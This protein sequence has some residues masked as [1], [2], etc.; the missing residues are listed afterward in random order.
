VHSKGLSLIEIDNHA[1]ENG[2][3]IDANNRERALHAGQR[4]GE[5]GTIGNDEHVDPHASSVELRGAVASGCNSKQLRAEPGS[6]ES[7]SR[8]ACALR[9]DVLATLHT[10]RWSRAVSGHRRPGDVKGTS[11]LRTSLSKDR[12]DAQV[13]NVFLVVEG[14]DLG[15]DEGLDAVPESSRCLAEGHASAQPCGRCRMSAVVYAQRLLAD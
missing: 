5:I 9:P 11:L 7:S 10:A 2:R 14:A 12:V 13:G 4:V 3:I 8:L 15:G 6:D 1:S